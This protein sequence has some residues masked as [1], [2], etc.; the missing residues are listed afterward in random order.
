MAEARRELNKDHAKLL[1][2]HKQSMAEYEKLLSEQ[3]L[4]DAQVLLDVAGII[5]PTPASDVASAAMSVARGD[6]GGA[7]LSL[8]SAFVPY[9]GDAIAKPLKGIKNA[10]RVKEVLE[11]ATKAASKAEKAKEKVLD[12]QR[13]VAALVR[14]KRKANPPPR[15]CKMWGT[16]LPADGKGSWTTK[17]PDGKSVPGV[18]GDCTWTS[19]DGTYSIDYK[20]GYPDFQTARLNGEKITWDPK[21]PALPD[22]DGKVDITNMKGTDAD[23]TQADRAMRERLGQS[24]WKRPTN[25]TWH[26]G[27]DGTS[28]TLVRSDGHHATYKDF[29]PPEDMPGGLARNPNV[30]AHSGGDSLTD[31]F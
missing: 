26:H 3:K 15:T 13:Q 25:Y 8:F 4:M 7:L 20:E 17:G 5:D 10:K 9:V 21:N 11:L 6:Y 12:A 16:R 24:D 31:E 23:F 27:E 22:F 29:T 1:E 18:K 19:K 2:E 30:P 28:M 14:K